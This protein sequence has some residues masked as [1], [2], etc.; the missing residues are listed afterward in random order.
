M[1]KRSLFFHKNEI[2]NPL[3][4][5]RFRALGSLP[6]LLLLST[7]LLHGVG[8]RAPNVKT[9]IY[10]RNKGLSFSKHDKH[11]TGLNYN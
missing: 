4:F 7:S 1:I 5:D 10:C 2:L 3:E 8:H 9:L 11:N 6:L